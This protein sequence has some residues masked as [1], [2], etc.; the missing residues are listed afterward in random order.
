M[1]RSEWGFL[2][3]NEDD[4]K[5]VAEVINKHNT[6]ENHDEVGEELFVFSIIK[7]KSKIYLC[8]GNGGGRCS[9]SLFLQN[10]YEGLIYY[11]FNQPKWWFE[12]TDDDYVWHTTDIETPFNPETVSPDIFVKRR[13][14]TLPE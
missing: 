1:G 7:H 10:N 4:L 9:T 2:I 5:R 6:H 14:K 12:T 11:P 3:K 13:K 8:A